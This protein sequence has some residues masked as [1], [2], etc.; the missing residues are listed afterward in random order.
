[1]IILGGL[2]GKAVLAMSQLVRQL[3][4]MMPSCSNDVLFSETCY[5]RLLVAEL[6]KHFLSVLAQHGRM[7]VY[8]AFRFRELDWD[9][10]LLDCAQGWMGDVDDH[11]ARQH[12]RV[13]ENIA[14]LIDGGAGYAT[15]IKPPH[16]FCGRLVEELL[17]K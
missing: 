12:L 16:P 8:G 5:I 10:C 1:M 9:P 4:M 15:F 3:E 7:P 14:D 17:L 13:R 6:G 2:S 11:L